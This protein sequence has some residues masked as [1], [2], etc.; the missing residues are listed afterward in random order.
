MKP[1]DIK[2]MKLGESILINKPPD[3]SKIKSKDIV[4]VKF[5]NGQT[6]KTKYV[7]NIDKNYIILKVT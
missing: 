6:C 7:H 5:K 2:N 1:F 3:F 4:M